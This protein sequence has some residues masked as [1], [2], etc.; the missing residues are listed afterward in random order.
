MR[1][2]EG[3]SESLACFQS[4]FRRRR[5]DPPGCGLNWWIKACAVFA[6]CASWT[7]ALPAQTFRTLLSFDS[8]DGFD[9]ASSLVQGTDGN[10]Y[11]TTPYGGNSG[12]SYGCG[13]VFK[14]SPRGKLTTLYKFCAKSNCAD[15]YGPFAGLVQAGDG[16][17]YGTTVWGGQGQQD[18]CGSPGC[19]T[20]F[21]ITPDG[22]LTTLYDFCS[23]S[24]CTDGASPQQALV[25]GRDGSL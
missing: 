16:N 8:T 20:F 25:Q 6:L 7:T 12:C 5:G 2:S 9:G 10:L 19:G 17:F 13:T 4:L 11:G 3:R 1:N 21:R 15:G 14:I 24:D 22:K 23:E 18:I